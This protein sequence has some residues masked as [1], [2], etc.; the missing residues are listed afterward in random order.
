MPPQTGADF[1]ELAEMFEVGAHHRGGL[2]IPIVVLDHRFG[3][4]QHQR[5][6]GGQLG[7]IQGAW[8]SPGSPLA[9]HFFDHVGHVGVV[10]TPH[11]IED[12]PNAIDFDQLRSDRGQ[13]Q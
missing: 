3:M 11:D 4:D 12:M 6:F 10:F 13:P 9:P 5:T 8:Q 7:E 1:F 2:G